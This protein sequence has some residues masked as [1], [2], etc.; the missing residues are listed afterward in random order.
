VGWRT[1]SALGELATDEK[2]NEI[3]AV[4]ALLDMLDIQGDVITADAMSC[5]TAI[6]HKIRETP[7]SI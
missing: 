4:P 5:Q 3:T 1:Q 6:V 7:R 2:S